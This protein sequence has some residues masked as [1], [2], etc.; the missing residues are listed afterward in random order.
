M[1]G[2][3]CADTRPEM[4]VRRLLHRLGYRY[5]THV[6]DFPGRPD[7]VFSKRRVV[8]QVHGCFWHQHAD[9][10]CTLRSKPKGNTDYWS[11]KLAR[12]VERD[13]EQAQAL[14]ERGWQTV[15]VWECQCSD[16]ARLQATLTQLLG[17]PRRGLP[18]TQLQPDP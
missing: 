18:A 1:R 10:S 14:A 6:K 2:N 7:L 17:P 12:N 8:V 15:I 16:E 3:K 13:A 5:R 4:L 9:P 11:A